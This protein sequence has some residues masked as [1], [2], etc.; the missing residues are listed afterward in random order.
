M[1]RI[2]AASQNKDKIREIEAITRKFG[3]DVVPR[4]DAGV[5]KVE[6]EEDGET[7]EENSY[8]KAYEVM[9]LCGE[10]TIAD[11]SGLMVDYIDGAPGVYSARF[12]GE[13]AT[14]D[15]NNEKL[16]GLLEGVPYEQR[17][18]KF[19]TVITLVYPDGE[20]IV[21][22]G[23]CPGHI[24]EEKRGGKDG[25]GF[26]YDPVFIP[27]G[28]D[29]TF[30]ELGTDIKNQVGHRGR[31]LAELERLLECYQKNE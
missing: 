6:I 27:E 10:T 25:F 11:D 15:S 7:F 18:A 30:A 22:R 3:M 5:P 4:D 28:F 16:L 14:Y 2:I 9:K 12:S 8:K 1:A 31:A 21:A 29:K 19:V 13:D 24:S 17:T 20:T 26:G 23:E